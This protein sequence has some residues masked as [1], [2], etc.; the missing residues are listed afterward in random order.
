MDCKTNG[1]VRLWERVAQLA[2]WTRHAYVGL[3]TFYI[4][5]MV[6]YH[7]ND[8]ALNGAHSAARYRYQ[9]SKTA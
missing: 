7:Y 6:I 9:K 1:L 8:R 5:Y 2:A 3:G 4:K